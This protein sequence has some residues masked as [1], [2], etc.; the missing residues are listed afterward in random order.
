MEKNENKSFITYSNY[1][2]IIIVKLNEVFA[3]LSYNYNFMCLSI[4]DRVNY[5]IKIAGLA[6]ISD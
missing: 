4:D 5:D 2:K 3:S 1:D 6:K